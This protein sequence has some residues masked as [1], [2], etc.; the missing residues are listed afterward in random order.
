[1]IVV[2]FLSSLPLR[3]SRVCTGRISRAGRR[4]SPDRLYDVL[5]YRIEVS[6]DEPKKMVMGNV[7]TT[8]VPFPAF[9][10]S[11]QFDAEEMHLACDPRRGRLTSV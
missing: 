2:R 7:T 1:M 6:F 5:H 9:L 8:L 4:G 3:T 10:N 11:I